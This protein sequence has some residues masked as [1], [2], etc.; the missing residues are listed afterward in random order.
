MDTAI[1]VK[2]LN[3]VALVTMM[4]SI[5]LTVKYEQVVAAAM[6]TRLVV[7][8]LVANFVLVPLVTIGLLAGF[9]ALPLVSAGFLVLAV[10]PAHRSDH[11]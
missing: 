8:A 6:Q 4:L 7:L 5:G 1:L 9:Q 10:C 3:V 2:L 11:P